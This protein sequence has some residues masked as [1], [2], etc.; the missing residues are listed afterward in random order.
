MCPEV[1]PDLAEHKRYHHTP[2]RLN[3]HGRPWT[4]AMAT[5]RTGTKASKARSLQAAW[6]AGFET[7]DDGV[8][9]AF[10]IARFGYQQLAHASRV[11]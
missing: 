5:D 10:G 7:T 1:Y 6:D 8:A 11:A 4:A 9:D 2:D 3:D